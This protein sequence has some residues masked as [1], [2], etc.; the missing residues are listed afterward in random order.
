[1]QLPGVHDPLDPE[2][3][4]LKQRLARRVRYEGQDPH[5]VRKEGQ[6]GAERG[7]QEREGQRGHCRGNQGWIGACRGRGEQGGVGPAGEG[8]R[9][10]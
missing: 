6:C 9:A 1:M 7:R 3:S 5:K 8:K 10:A 4:I 2:Y